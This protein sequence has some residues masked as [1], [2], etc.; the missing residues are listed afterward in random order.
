M[1]T[2]PTGWTQLARM[3][4][5]LDNSDPGPVTTD[6]TRLISQDHVNFRSGPL[7]SLLTASAQVA[8]VPLR[9]PPGRGRCAVGLDLKLPNLFA[10]STPVAG[11]LVPFANRVG[12]LPAS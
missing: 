6:Y 8:A 12:S 3:R 10:V 11:Q 9:V 1:P 4:I 7:P 2:Y 5:V